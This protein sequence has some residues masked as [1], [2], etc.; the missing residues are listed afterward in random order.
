M[1]DSSAAFVDELRSLWK[2]M[3]FTK[4]KDIERM[5]SR[6]GARGQNLSIVVYAM[7]D[8]SATVDVLYYLRLSIKAMGDN[9]KP[10]VDFACRYLESV[11]SRAERY[12]LLFDLARITRKTIQHLENVQTAQ[13]FLSLV[14]AYML[15]VGKLNYWIDYEMPWDEKSRD[16]KPIAAAEQ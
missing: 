2:S 14:E 6:V 16:F 13:E 8:T 15:Y 1:P 4:P 12:Y 7:G 10:F 5:R 9:F 11:A 3:L